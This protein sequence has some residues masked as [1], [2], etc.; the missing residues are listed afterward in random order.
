M[1]CG[2]TAWGWRHR[3]VIEREIADEAKHRIATWWRSRR[4]LWAASYKARYGVAATQLMQVDR[5]AALRGERRNMRCCVRRA[6]QLEQQAKWTDET[7]VV[8]TETGEAI[9]LAKVARQP[10][11]RRAELHVVT[12]D[13]IDYEVA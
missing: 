4:S 11:Q 7:L 5:T 8:D 6:E 10:R 3:G 2:V 9:P 13:M 12:R 1:E